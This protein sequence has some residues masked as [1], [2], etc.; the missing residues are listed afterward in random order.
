MSAIAAIVAMEILDSRGNPTLEVLVETVDGV[1]AR[2]AVPSG[3]STGEH[4]ALEMRDGDPKRYN[5][6][7]VRKAIENVNG[8]LATLLIGENVLDQAH[9]DRIMIEADGTETK[10]EL[11]ANAILGIS[12]AVARAGAITS[13]LPLYRYLGG[14]DSRL[15]PC[16]MMN[17][18]NGGAH[19]S[20][21]L[22]FQEF[23]I[24]PVGAPTLTEAIRWGAE[25]FHA[26]K[27]VLKEGGHS[28]NVGDE[29]GFAPNLRSN[30]EGIEAI[31][32]AIEK[33]GY[34]AGQELSL[35]LDCAASEFYDRE[36]GRYLEKKK[37]VKGETYEQRTSSQQAD[38][39][40]KLA[41]QYPIDSIEDGLDENDWEGWKTL[42]EK[43]GK[44]LQIVG[45][46]LF[47]TNPKFLAKGIAMGVANSILIKLNQIGTVTETLDT[48]ALARAHGY[49]T[50]ISHRS[51]ETADDFIADLAVASRSGQIKTG[52]LSR[53]DRVAKYNRLMRIEAELGEAALYRDSNRCRYTYVKE[54]VK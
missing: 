35:A 13:G 47:V 45:D 16:P 31:L 38:Y 18:I 26:L 33:A 29:G 34:K 43:G 32:K 7:G 12:L 36:S 52:S 46:D 19:A 3:A 17:I 25:V 9:I 4:E 11:G 30:E 53:T 44:R 22:D 6:K 54:Q 1:L 10:A 27:A 50:V 23:M 40:V 15:L 24:R 20:N 37:K 39:L 48:I 14:C 28:T 5:G 49:T 2:A 51:G 41:E 8:R 42:T 21:S